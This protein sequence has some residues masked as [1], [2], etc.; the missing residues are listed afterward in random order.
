MVYGWAEKFLT[1]KHR[2]SY[3][4]VPR[5]LLLEVMLVNKYCSNTEKTLL[6]TTMSFNGQMTHHESILMAM[7][8]SVCKEER[9]M[10]VENIFRIREE[11][12]K[13]WVTPTGVWPFKVILY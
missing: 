9:R 8:E 2:N 5:V 1:I 10:A 11:G 3:L 13:L 7:L 6:S 12:P 4:Q